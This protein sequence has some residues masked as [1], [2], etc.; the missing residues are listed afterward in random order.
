LTR[1]VRT[2]RQKQ[3]VSSGQPRWQART[4]A[5]AAGLTDHIWTIKELLTMMAVPPAIN[6]E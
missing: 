6:T 2:L 5:I 3:A 1:P 4:P